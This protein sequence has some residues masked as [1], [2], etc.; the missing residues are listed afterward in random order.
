[1]I[2]SNKPVIAVVKGPA[3]AGGCGLAS[4]CDYIISTEN[5]KFGYPEVKIGFVAA[6]VSVFLIRQIGERKA[7]QLLLTGELLDPSSA[8][9]F[10]LINEISETTHTNFPLAKVYREAL[11]ILISVCPEVIII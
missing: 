8:L 9:N 7:R 2:N 11:S 5:G 10:G 1:M 3:I 6:I 4:V